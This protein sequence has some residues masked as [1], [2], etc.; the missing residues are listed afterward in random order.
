ME[1]VDRDMHHV[2]VSGNLKP[3]RRLVFDLAGGTMMI[4]FP[5]S[6]GPGRAPHWEELRWGTGD[7]KCLC[8]FIRDRAD[9][10]AFVVM[11]A[12][13]IGCYMKPVEG[14]RDLLT[15]ELHRRD[16]SGN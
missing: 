9:A 6:R 11:L 5:R 12:E 15:F 1:I 8:P 10:Q 4:L 13:I 3:G 2:F 7:N 16:P 14:P